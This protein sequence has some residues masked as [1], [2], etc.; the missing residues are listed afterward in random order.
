MEWYISV[1]CKI[2]ITLRSFFLMF[3][4][5]LPWAKTMCLFIILAWTD[6][7]CPFSSFLLS[8]FSPQISQVICSGLIFKR[9]LQFTSFSKATLQIGCIYTFLPS[10]TN[11]MC[12]FSSLWLSNFLSHW[13]QFS[14]FV[15][16]NSTHVP[17]ILVHK[18]LCYKCHIYKVIL[19]SNGSNLRV[20]S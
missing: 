17:I 14:D 6:E 2:Q 4:R 10:C 20:I 12:T 8:N 5:F 18:S 7:M 19:S 3:D 15:Y 9:P 1:V 16:E 13:A 11:R